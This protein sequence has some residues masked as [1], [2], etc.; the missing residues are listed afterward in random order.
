MSEDPREAPSARGARRDEA[1]GVGRRAVADAAARSLPA[2]VGP[3]RPSDGVLPSRAGACGNGRDTPDG[4]SLPPVSAPGN[5]AMRPDGASDEERGA[6]PVASRGAYALDGL[7]EL[8]DSD[9]SSEVRTP[10]G[11]EADQSGTQ[12]RRRRELTPVQRALGLLVRREH[13]RKELNRK[14]TARGITSEDAESA[15]SRLAEAGWQ[16]DTRFAESLVRARVSGGYGPLHIRA[17]LATHGLDREAV[18]SALATFE[19]EWADIARDLVRRR[20]GQDV[21]RDLGLHRKA[22]QLLMRRGF[23][24]SCVR[25]ATRFDPDE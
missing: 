3:A 14:L 16:D 12:R 2:A 17:E 23:D 18:A 22:A 4:S 20:Y 6:A 24:S 19:G 9:D 1:P 21:S 25:A 8:R 10:A 11:V 15:V 13:S 7:G 5:G